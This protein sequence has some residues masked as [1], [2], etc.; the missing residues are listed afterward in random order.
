[1]HAAQAEEIDIATVVISPGQEYE[2]PYGDGGLSEVSDAGA[3]LVRPGG[4]VAFRYAAAAPDVGK[5]LT[6]AVRQILGHV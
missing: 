5:L 6:G 3:L 4:F 2:D 1:M